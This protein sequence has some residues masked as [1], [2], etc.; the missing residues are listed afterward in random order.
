MFLRAI[1]TSQ[2]IYDFQ[3]QEFPFATATHFPFDLTET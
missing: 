1:T 3:S 2:S